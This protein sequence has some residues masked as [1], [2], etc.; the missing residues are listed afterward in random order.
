M[1]SRRDDEEWNVLVIG[2]RGETGK[3]LTLLGEVGRFRTGGYPQVLIGSVARPRG[4]DDLLAGIGELTA[5]GERCTGVIDRVIP[6]EEAVS[7]PRDDVTETL[8][9][10]FEPLAHRL[11]GKTF[12]VRAHLRGLKGRIEHP[13]VER[14]LGDFLSEFAARAG[15][16]PKVRFRDP[17]TVVVVEVVGRRVGYAFVGREERAQPL[18]R[19]K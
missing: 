11:C 2:T 1:A 4:K 12:Y 3:A 14:A 10:R 6:V 8:C 9:E 13:A 17:D 18:L 5:G 7:F 19:V 16:P 15:A